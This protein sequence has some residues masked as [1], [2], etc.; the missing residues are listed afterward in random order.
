MLSACCPVSSF[1]TAPRCVDSFSPLQPPGP[2]RNPASKAEEESWLCNLEGEGGRALTQTRCGAEEAVLSPELRGQAAV[3]FSQVRGCVRPQEEA[4]WPVTV[5]K[6]PAELPAGS[7]GPWAGAEWLFLSGNK[8]SPCL[9]VCLRLCVPRH[10]LFSSPKCSL[11][12]ATLRARASRISRALLHRSSQVHRA[13]GGQ[14]RREG[15]LFASV[16]CPRLP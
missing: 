11:R 13:L 6:D 16:D 1:S 7:P 3:S 9:Q 15:F 12:Q 10:F 14:K 2:F 5:G 4:E 8:C